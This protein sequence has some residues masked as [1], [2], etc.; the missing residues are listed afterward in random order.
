MNT[1]NPNVEIRP[2]TVQDAQ[3]L[4]QIYAHYV[5]Q[6][7]ITFEYAA[8]SEKEFAERMERIMQRYPYLVAQRGS[9]VLGY[10]YAG[11]FKERAA[12]DWSC[13]TTIYL[14]RNARRQGAGRMLYDALETELADM[15]IAN[16]YACIAYTSS[17]DEYLT[18]DSVRFH[19][20]MGFAQVGL[21]RNCGSK[22]GR[23]YDMVWMEKVIGEHVPDQP[24]IRSWQPR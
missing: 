15:G 14:D 3:R 22:F 7:A 13:E 17:P 20:R 18:L 9:E 21:F 1:D 16:L 24:P 5:E 10:A 11:P 19:E 6:T 8:P 4:A 23:W 2:A 12:Y